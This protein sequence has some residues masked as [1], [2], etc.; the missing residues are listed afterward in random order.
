M[1]FYNTRFI[2][3]PNGT[4]SVRFFQEPIKFN[5]LTEEQKEQQK[6]QRE[7]EKI[8]Q[9]VRVP[10]GGVAKEVDDLEEIELSAEEKMLKEKHSLQVSMNRTVNRIY[11]IARCNNWEW[12]L[13]MTFKENDDFDSCSKK[14]REWLKN[15]RKRYSPELMYLFVPELHKKGGWHFHGLISNIGNL[16]LEIAT[17]NNKTSKFYG[18]SLRVNYP[19]GDYIYN[20][21]NFKSGFTTAT[22]I[23]DTRRA[24]NY[25]MKYITKDLCKLT[26]NKHRYYCSKDLPKPNKFLYFMEEKEFNLAIQ[27]FLESSDKKIDYTKE[28]EIDYGGYNNKI[29]YLE[30]N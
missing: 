1:D 16:Q 13:T 24:S 3:Y 4:V 15:V 8:K 12:F 23:K 30:I 6:E 25:I 20:L 26:K 7:I 28:I 10:F 18:D 2:Q 11:D 21:A 27:D 17:N 19:D 29:T 5:L 22:R 9:L 14:L